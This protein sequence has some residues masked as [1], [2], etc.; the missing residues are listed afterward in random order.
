MLPQGP[1]ATLQGEAELRQEKPQKET[2]LERLEFSRKMK[3]T[4]I[5][6]KNLNEERM[7]R[8]NVSYIVTP[9]TLKILKWSLYYRNYVCSLKK[10]KQKYTE[11]I[12]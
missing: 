11:E 6:S 8:K 10:F 4:K 9:S 5:V 12:K 3:E 1:K 2:E 7:S